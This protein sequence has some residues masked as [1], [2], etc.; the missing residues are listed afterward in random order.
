MGLHRTLSIAALVITGIL[1]T[2]PSWASD[3]FELDITTHLG[4]QQTFQR[5]DTLSLLVTM[6]QDAHL[7]II[8]QDAK[9][10]FIQILPSQ[11]I[12][13]SFYKAGFYFPIPNSQHLFRLTIRPP[14]G[15]E[16]VW[17]FA[18]QHTPPSLSGR[19]L[20]NGFRLLEGNMKQIR[21][22]LI[23]KAN[24]LLG[25]AHVEIITTDTSSQ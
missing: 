3:N 4:D 8:Y 9:N 14:F 23:S 12:P 6:N 17:A 24:S 10:N 7:L 22:Q 5:G 16:Y 11:H 25:E 13:T 18:T 15:H 19:K 2:P 21:E 1:F 20:N